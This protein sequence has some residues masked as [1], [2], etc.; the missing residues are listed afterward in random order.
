MIY[1][2]TGGHDIAKLALERWQAG[3]SRES[4]ELSDVEKTLLS[5]AINSDS[6]SKFGPAF[7][8]G[9]EFME[10]AVAMW[11]ACLPVGPLTCDQPQE[12]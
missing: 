12:C 4:L 2:N 5:S 8:S 11:L 6:H 7:M 1:S 10:A 3:I 9:A